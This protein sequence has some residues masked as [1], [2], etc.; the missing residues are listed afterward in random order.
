MMGTLATV[1]AKKK[2]RTFQDRYAATVTGDIESV[3][4]VLKI[5]RINVSYNL[6]LPPH[7]RE[8]AQEAF[9]NYI[10]HCP[11]AQSVIDAIAI[12]HEL[13]IEDEN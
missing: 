6:K 3:N 4:G 2:I 13:H 5:T 7:K 8:D 11:A 1:L 12:N 10:V 9:G